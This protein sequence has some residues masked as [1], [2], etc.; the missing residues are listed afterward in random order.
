M[1]ERKYYIDIL[2]FISA[3]LVIG[4]HL[5]SVKWYSISIIGPQWHFLNVYN[6]IARFSVPVF[7]MASGA[8]LL[9]PKRQLDVKTLFTKYMSKIILVYVVW[10]L[11][12]SILSIV[13]EGN[14]VLGVELIKQLLYRTIEGPKHFW[15]LFTL[16]GIYLA[17]PILRE[18]VKNRKL[19]EY[20][21][22]IS[23]VFVV[24]RSVREIIVID[25]LELYI[26]Y[27]DFNFTAGN[28][29]YF[30][31]GYYL[32][33]FDISKNTRTVLYMLTLA[34]IIFTVMMTI[35]HSYDGGIAYEGF[36]GYQRPAIILTSVGVFVAFKAKFENYAFSDKIKQF[37]LNTSSLSLG[38]YIIHLI[39]VNFVGLYDLLDIL[40]IYFSL[41]LFSLLIYL[42]S[43]LIVKF[44][45][46]IKVLK[47]FI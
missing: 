17:V 14:L 6:S 30:V 39:F 47:L 9:D 26:Q 27:L 43:A 10:S 7:F 12:Y 20:Y 23:L 11:I 16:G 4:I 28:I 5:S 18:V 21:L 37:L 45:M 34:S 1:S 44:L 40:P 25:T 35:N 46:N 22:L 41:P 15:Y 2:K 32:V 3:I 31:L 42:I 29:L 19:I 36:Y 8:F 13:Q 33:N 24:F 38:V